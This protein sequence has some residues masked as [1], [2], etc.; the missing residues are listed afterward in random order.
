MFLGIF[1]PWQI[2]A[3]LIKTLSTVVTWLN[4][5][6]ENAKYEK[7]I[8]RNTYFKKICS[9]NICTIGHVKPI[10]SQIKPFVMRQ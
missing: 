8:K 7:C 5:L 1:E 10:L 4:L 6:I 2:I 9:N 3:K